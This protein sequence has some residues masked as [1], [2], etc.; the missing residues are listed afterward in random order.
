VRRDLHEFRR[1]GA[2]GISS[3]N[4]RRESFGKLSFAASLPNHGLEGE[5]R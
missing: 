2:L 1:D 4:S 3:P 5:L